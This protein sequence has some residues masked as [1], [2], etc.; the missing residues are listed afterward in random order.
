M[1]AIQFTLEEIEKAKSIRSE[2]DSIPGEQ[3]FDS[4]KRYLGKLGQW[5][6]AR[7]IPQW[8]DNTNDFV[9]DKYD[10]IHNRT[11]ERIEVKANSGY[12]PWRDWFSVACDYDQ[13][14]ENKY[15]IVV[16][17]CFV[18]KTLE[19]KPI[20]WNY[21]EEFEKHSS[22]RFYKRWDKVYNS[23]GAFMFNVR[24]RIGLFSWDSSVLLPME[25]LL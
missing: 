7:L 13:W 17:C 10:F 21:R 23:K 18:N 4:D 14:Q 22:K 25:S 24:N 5:T 12:L 11:G 8:I 3:R 6:I 9:A 15:P 1:Q 19:C 2:E 20:G 16:F